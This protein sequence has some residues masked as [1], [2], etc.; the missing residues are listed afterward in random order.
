MRIQDLKRNCV[1]ILPHKRKL[2]V[3]TQVNS[4]WSCRLTKLDVES[5]QTHTKQEFSPFCSLPKNAFCSPFLSTESNENTQMKW[6]WSLRVTKLDF[7]SS[8]TH[9]KQRFS[10]CCG[11]PKSS[12]CTPFLSTECNTNCVVGYVLTIQNLDG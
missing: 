9:K 12:F 7:E 4:E 3:D 10:P 5:S 6:E 8:K 1:C 2:T 11:L